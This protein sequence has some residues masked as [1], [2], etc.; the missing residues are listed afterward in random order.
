M[1]QRMI[2]DVNMLTTLLPVALLLVSSKKVFEGSFFWNDFNKLYVSQAVG[3]CSWRV[4][5]TAL[6]AA[7]LSH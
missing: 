2:V 5:L 1:R 7:L 6:V 3:P 4:E